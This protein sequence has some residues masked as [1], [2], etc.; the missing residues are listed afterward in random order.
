MPNVVRHDGGGRPPKAKAK[1]ATKAPVQGPRIPPAGGGI[2]PRVPPAP[3]NNQRTPAGGSKI[4]K[5]QAQRA[6]GGGNN[7]GGYSP[8]GQIDVGSTGSYAPTVGDVGGGAAVAAP[9]PP[10]QKKLSELTQE[11]KDAIYNSDTQLTTEQSALKTILDNLNADL[12]LQDEDYNRGYT[13]NL[14]DVGWLGEG[15][16]YDGWDRDNLQTSYGSSY[17]GNTNDFAGRGMFNSTAYV[18]ALSRMND[19]FKDQVG[20]LGTARDSFLKGT[21]AQRSAGQNTYNV[22]LDAARLQALQRAAAENGWAA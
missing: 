1:V 14:S 19:D 20:G 4:S 15:K 7:G 8:G 10:P 3:A 12:G 17:A 16:G 11:E 18:E 9:E 6:S 13:K 2:G 5:P 22:S 21:A